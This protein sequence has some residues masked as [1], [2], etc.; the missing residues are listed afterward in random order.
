M[1]LVLHL[2]SAGRLG[3]PSNL[4]SDSTKFPLKHLFP[5]S[6]NS[7]SPAPKLPARAAE[8]VALVQKGEGNLI[9]GAGVAAWAQLDM[10][11]RQRPG[12]CTT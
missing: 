4:Q 12:N 11:M 1:T 3:P 6:V 2:D 10:L 9:F 8:G 5:F 7:V